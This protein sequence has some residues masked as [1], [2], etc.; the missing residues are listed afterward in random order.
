MNWDLLLTHA[1]L[2]TF[3]GEASYGL[4]SD[5]AV[6]CQDGQIAWIGS[7]RD[8]PAASASTAREVLDLDGALVTPGLIDCHTHLVFGGDRAQEFIYGSMAPRMKRLRAPAAASFPPYGP[9]AMPA[10]TNCSRNRC[11]VRAPCW[12]MA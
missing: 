7:M 5:A 9:R 2:A 8:L 4:L 11:R 6:A 1:S 12:P 10:K 3:V